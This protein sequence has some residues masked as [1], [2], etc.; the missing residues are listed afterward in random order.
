MKG[1]I[2]ELNNIASQVYVDRYEADDDDA[3]KHSK[4]DECW[5]WEREK[6]VQSQ[7]GGRKRW[8]IEILVERVW[9]FFLPACRCI[10]FISSFHKWNDEHF[11][12]LSFHFS[13]L[14]CGRTQFYQLI[15]TDSYSNPRPRR[16]SF[17]CSNIM[18]DESF[19]I[20]HACM[21]VYKHI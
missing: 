6:I 5:E 19:L 2:S 1:K 18:A 21:Y 16:L 14:L 10:I 17:I 3:R 4:R 7:S 20:S 8:V 15:L 12:S 9:N 11:F 13:L